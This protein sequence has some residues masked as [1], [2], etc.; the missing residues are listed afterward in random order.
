MAKQIR[1]DMQ[2]PGLRAF[3]RDLNSLDKEANKQLRAASIDIARRYMV[4]AWSMAALEAGSWGDKI[5]RTV[6]AKSDRIPVVIIGSNRR[7]YSGGASVNQ[8]R[9]ASSFG[10]SKRGRKNPKAAGAIAAFGTGTGWMKGVGDGYKEPAMREWASA[11]EKVVDLYNN[12]R[13]YG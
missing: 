7:A 1:N 4:P 2:V 13:T 10:V 8:V 12:G 6:K 9:N 11:A 5:L 3:M